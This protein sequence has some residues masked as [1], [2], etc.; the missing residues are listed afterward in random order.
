METP[1]RLL[2]LPTMRSQQSPHFYWTQPGD[3]LIMRIGGML[4]RTPLDELPQLSNALRDEMPLI[5]PRPEKPEPEIKLKT[6]I[7]HY[8]NLHWMAPCVSGWAQAW[9]PYAAT[10]E[11]DELMLSYDLFCLR[12]W[13]V[14]MDFSSWLKP[15]K[16]FLRPQDAE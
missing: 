16:Q 6:A 13:N 14:A 7:P 1:V 8:R 2:K 12:N 3:A 5:S 9:A 15:L 10:V 11:E 4:L